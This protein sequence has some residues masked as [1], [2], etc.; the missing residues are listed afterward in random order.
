MLA[1]LAGAAPTGA[2]DVIFTEVHYQPPESGGLEFI[3]I[4]NAG[5]RSV[6]LRGW[7]FTDGVRFEFVAPTPLAPGAYLVLAKNRAELL[8]RFPLDGALV[9][10]DFAGRLGD[11]GETLELV[12]GG[13][14][15]VDALSYNDGF[16]FEKAADGGG[17]SLQ[18]LCY[19][20]PSAAPYNW[21]AASP[22]PG[23]AS[24][25]RLCPPAPRPIDAGALPIVISEIDYHPAGAGDPAHEYVELANRGSSA[26]D[27]SGWSFDEGFLYTFPAGVRLEPGEFLLVARD[28]A[29]L[30]ARMP[31]DPARVFGP[32][33]GGTQLDNGGEAIRLVDGAGAVQDRVRYGQDDLWPV[34]ADGLGGSLQRVDLRGPSDAPG[35]WRVTPPPPPGPQVSEWMEL[36][37]EGF[38]SGPRMYF[39]LLDA[40]EML[41]DDVRLEIKGGDGANLLVNGGFDAGLD[42]WSGTGNH[43]AS[44]VR[45]DGG[46][47]DN[48]PCCVVRAADKGNGFQNALRQTLTTALATDVAVILSFKVKA[49]SGNSALIGRCSLATDEN[50][51]LMIEG[52]ARS[53]GAQKDRSPLEASSFATDATPPTVGL[54]ELSPSWPTSRDAVTVRARVI[55]DD[56]DLVTAHYQVG[57]G[58]EREVVLADGG[59]GN[60]EVAGDGIWSGA[61]PPAPN[62]SLVWVSLRARGAGGLVTEWPRLKNP[63]TVTGYYVV[64]D[65][66]ETNEDVRLFYIFTPGGLRDLTCDTGIYTKGDFVDHEGRAYR[67]IGMKFRGETACGYPKR[68]MRARFNKGDR[69]EGLSRLNFMAGW[70]DKSMLREPFGFDFFREAGVPYSETRM[71]MVYTSGNVLNGVYFTVED[72]NEDYVERNRLDAAGGLYKARSAMLDAGTGA[73]EPRTDASPGRLQEIG[74]F[75]SQMNARTGQ[76][77]IDFLNSKLDVEEVIDYQA[78]QVIIIDGDSVVKNWLLYL[79]RFDGYG[80]GSDLVM[81]FPWDIDLSHGQMLLTTDVRNYDIHPLFQTQSYPF[82]DQGYHGILNALLQ[83]A[84]NDYYVKA[85]Y[86]RMHKLIEEKFKPAVLFPKLDR[87]RDATD[88]AARADLRRWPRTWG[89][90]GND[91]DYWRADFRTFVERRYA[92]LSNYLRQLNVTTLGRRFQYTPAPRVR[93]SEIH[94]NPAGGG[95]DLEFI[96]LVNLEDREVALAGWN[97]PAVGFTFGA[98]ARL[99]A[100]GVAVVAKNP[101][102]LASREDMRGA[103]LFG[104][105][106]GALDNGGAILRLRD[107]G[108]AGKYYPETIDVVAYDDGDGWPESADGDGRSLELVSAGLDNDSPSSWRAGWSPGRAAERNAAPQAAIAADPRSGPAPLT[109]FLSALPSSD[110]DGDELSFLWSLPGGRIDERSVLTLAI[111]GAGVFTVGLSVRDAFGGEASTSVT[112]T[113]S[114]GGG[115]RFVR[116]DANAD[117]LV[118]L[119]D[120]VH[121]L[122]FLFTGGDAPDC[123]KSADLNDSAGVDLSDPLY[124]LNFLFLGGPAVPPPHPDCG[125]DPSADELGCEPEAACRDS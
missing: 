88:E 23:A 27:L 17:A 37:A 72:P 30:L 64:D 38:W 95:D 11:D 99:P 122:N 70:N 96:E 32:F 29:A 85:F 12:D 105:Y 65:R 94:Y 90:R 3:E 75:A 98:G 19:A 89:A 121:V 18:R 97:I 51:F 86:G 55:G 31:L 115:Q 36:R 87:Y 4:H 83:R 100:R 40:G 84:P 56:V 103:E 68:P 117:A 48:G 22:S 101:A 53:G 25:E 33:A 13:G 59:S 124:L 104:P 14:R 54:H 120:A 57:A 109:V 118:N 92:F 42:P 5:S 125:F 78:V 2:A 80:P 46:F 107:D 123:L 67:G 24:A 1:A 58:P 63:S 6:D 77:L 82:H 110:A 113:V 111:D 93:L 76:P 106:A 43:G 119:A 91:L 41:L 15:T 7:S 39:Y 8:A 9:L 16:P 20:A 52:D 50:G 26:V 49:L 81:M 34:F 114:E 21:R 10:G 108:E 45:A 62:L 112:L 79:G 102:V 71:V 66:P 116:G 73:Y 44:G 61:I 74:L 69:F 28:R 47:G 60:D 35:N